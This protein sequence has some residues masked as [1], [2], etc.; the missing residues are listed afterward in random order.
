MPVLCI[1]TNVK[2]SE[3]KDL[4]AALKDLSA[5]VADITGKPEAYVSVLI[6]P[7]QAMIFGGSTEPCGLASFQC[8]GKLGVQENK[9]HAAT[10][11]PLLD[12]HLGIKDDRMY[13]HFQDIDRSNMGYKSATFH[14]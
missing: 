3:I 11:Y 2:S 10:L 6:K 13:I 1:E 8:I 7:D 9:Q 5:A 14:K 4:P 12:Q